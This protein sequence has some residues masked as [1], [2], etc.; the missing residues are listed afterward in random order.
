MVK[1]SQGKY[2]HSRTANS[3]RRE[4]VEKLMQKCIHVNRVGMRVQK[5]TNRLS[6][7]V[8]RACSESEP[9]EKWLL[10]NRNSWLFSTIPW[11]RI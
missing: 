8:S 1:N 10:C 9:R 2:N 3:S 7:C 5:S 4:Y 6:M 11:L